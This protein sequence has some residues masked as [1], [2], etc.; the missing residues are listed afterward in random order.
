V[1]SNGDPE[2]RKYLEPDGYQLVPVKISSPDKLTVPEEC[3]DDT[4]AA[5]ELQKIVLD[6]NSKKIDAII[7]MEN[8]FAEI[9][10]TVFLRYRFN[11]ER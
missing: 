5:A 7:A 1:A 8:L 9:R 6:P 2:L 11:N 4:Q 10:Q 3:C